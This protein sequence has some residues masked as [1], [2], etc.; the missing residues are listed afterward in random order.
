MKKWIDSPT[1]KV[2]DLG[3]D[4]YSLIRPLAIGLLDFEIKENVTEVS[5]ASDIK[6]Y[7]GILDVKTK[8]RIYRQLRMFDAR[9]GN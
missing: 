5:L 6:D 2:I 3:D 7:I 8:S 1:D 9:V 4:K